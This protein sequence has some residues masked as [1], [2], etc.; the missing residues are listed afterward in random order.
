[1]RTQALVVRRGLSLSLKIFLGTAAVV[2]A[3]LGG[4]LYATARGAEQAAS[5]TVDRALG[6]A[7][8]QL[9]TQLTSRTR[10]LQNVM[11]VAVDNPY[12]R[13]RVESKVFE[14]VLD[15]AQ[16]MAQQVGA[17][18]TQITD[19]DGVRLAKSDLPTASMD[20]LGGP[21]IGSALSGVAATG[22][23]TSGDTALLQVA[24]VPVQ[25]ASPGTVVG[26]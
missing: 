16:V 20:T 15:Q 14:D 21:L 17:D 5:R 18:W 25:G 13:A 8:V 2:A 10:A 19:G 7:R 26:R 3:V 6:A 4:T 1:M 23:G 22:Y 24:A 9:V 11:S 12:F